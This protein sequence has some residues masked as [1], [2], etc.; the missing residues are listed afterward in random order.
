MLLS[1]GETS[2]PILS[3]QSGGAYP[4]PN[5]RDP[6]DYVSKLFALKALLLLY[7]SPALTWKNSAFYP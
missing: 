1:S 5:L 7:R 4:F 3:G 2:T 6:P